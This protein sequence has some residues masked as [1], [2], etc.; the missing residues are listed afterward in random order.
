MSIL[1]KSPAGLVATERLYL[2]R[3][4]RVVLD[5]D[6][7]AAFLLA[8]EGAE[9]PRS[10]I[11]HHGLTENTA[12]LPPLKPADVVPASAEEFVPSKTIAN[13]SIDTRTDRAERVSRR[14]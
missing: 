7:R 3:D 5:G 2:T 9:V 13:E 4:G 6:V 12:P 1:K 8:P 10:A 14:R 11:H